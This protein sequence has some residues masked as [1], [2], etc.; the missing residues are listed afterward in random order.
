MRTT[1]H[2]DTFRNKE[3]SKIIQAQL[4]ARIVTVGTELPNPDT[5]T[6]LDHKAL[7]HIQALTEGAL[8]CL[9]V[10][11]WNSL[12]LSRDTPSSPY[13]LNVSSVYK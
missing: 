2:V 6:A 12:H 1:C 5:L 4:E 10:E 13:W 11:S 9:P 8:H 3:T 7:P